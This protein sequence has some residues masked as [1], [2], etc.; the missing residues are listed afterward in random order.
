[1]QTSPRI[2][3]A[4]SEHIVRKLAHYSIYTLLG[5]LASLTVGRRRLFSKKSLGVLL[6][7]FLYACSDEIHQIFVPGRAGMFTDV[8][9]DT[10]GALTGMLISMA[11]MWL[12]FRIKSRSSAKRAAA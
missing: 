2:R 8:L 12:Y 5:F 7:C 9:I 4:E 3:A 11:A 6:F 1:M 10:S